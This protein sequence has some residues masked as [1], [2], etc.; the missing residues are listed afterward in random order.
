MDNQPTNRQE[1]EGRLKNA[2][3]RLKQ[4]LSLPP[5]ASVP[6]VLPANLVGATDEQKELWQLRVEVD[7]LRDHYERLTRYLVRAVVAVISVVAPTFG[8]TFVNQ[9]LKVLGF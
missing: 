1:A 8:W 3:A 9:V 6:L 5:S 2:L 4:G 7:G